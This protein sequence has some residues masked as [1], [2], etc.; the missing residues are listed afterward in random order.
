MRMLRSLLCDLCRAL[1]AGAALSDVGNADRQVAM[2]GD[3]AKKSFDRADFRNAGI[4]K[5]TKIILY[6]GE[7][8][9]HV[10]IPHGQDRGFRR[11]MIQNRL[12]QRAAGIVERNRIR[13]TV[14][15]FMALPAVG[16]T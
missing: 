5:S 1:D 8:L 10:R 4:G 12:Q 6:R 16:T 11:G 9:R 3:L 7:I 2:N 14:R 13:Q 15:A